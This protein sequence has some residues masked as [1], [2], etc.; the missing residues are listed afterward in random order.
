MSLDMKNLNE[1]DKDELIALLI[2]TQEELKQKK[3]SLRETR[4]RLLSARRKVKSLG[5][6]I[7]FQRKR[8]VDLYANQT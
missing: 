2:E 6:T 1:Y 3:Q 8:I 5:E 4:S 7:K